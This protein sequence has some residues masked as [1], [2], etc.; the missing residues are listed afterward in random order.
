MPEHES[1][2]APHFLAHHDGD[3]VA[4]AV[5]DVSPGPATVVVLHGHQSRTVD[6]RD[7]IP[8][9]HKVALTELA[10]GAEVIEYGVRVAVTSEP[11][12]AGGYVH[13]HNVRSARWQTSVAR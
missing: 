11:V 12:P 9:G 4:V 7:P 5:Q 13:T 8:L 3:H 10:E 1:R 2:T 6:V